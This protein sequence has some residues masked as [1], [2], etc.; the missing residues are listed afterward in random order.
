MCVIWGVGPGVVTQEKGQKETSFG[1]ITRNT[2]FAQ[3]LLVLLA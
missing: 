2:L 1:K 3:N